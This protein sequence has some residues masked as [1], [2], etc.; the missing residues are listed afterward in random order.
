[1]KRLLRGSFSLLLCGL[2]VVG[3]ALVGC[4]TGA[5]PQR[6]TG[7][8]VQPRPVT[9]P[10]HG[11]WVA[12]F[13]YRHADDV[14]TIMRN[15]AE[16]GFNTVYWQVRGAGTVAY[17]SSIEPWSPEFNFRDPGFDPLA[18][19]VEEAHQHGLR[20]EAWVNVLPGW[21]GEQPPPVRQ[22]LWNAHPDWFLR[23]AD[24][25]RQ[26]LTIVDPKTKLADSFYV[27]LNPCLPEVRQHIVRV[28]E[29]IVSRYD[30]D[31]VHLDYVRY[32][33]DTTPDAANKYPRD[34]RT[35]AIYKRETGKRPD[36]DAEAWKH[37]RANQLT[38]L[39]AS[40][41]QMLDR[42]RP[43]ATLTAAVV[44]NPRTAYDSFFQNG[45]AWLRTGM[46]DALLPMAYSD[47][48]GPFE[49]DIAAYREAV[50]GRRIVP[51]VGI[52]KHTNGEIMRQQ[53][54]RCANWGGDFA[55]FS[56]ES[57]YPTHQDRQSSRGP[58]AQTRAQRQQRRA[59]LRPFVGK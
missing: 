32:A 20:I 1:M 40:I 52:Y 57:L 36:D 33:W 45:V 19:A 34:A 51:G 44:R 6:P 27:I 38:R 31:G 9:E 8:R 24:G 11:V 28:I 23:D 3:G 30:V 55:L 46:V 35:L 43:G 22:Q 41:R 17:P 7:R 59:A 56:Y 53:L 29:E 50:G 18:I 49:A 10:V 39:V 21:R 5:G 25:H 26:P 58:S 42:R 14:R 15:C 48:L 4:Q 54:A 47:Q 16:L 37:W 2:V 12:R 13:H